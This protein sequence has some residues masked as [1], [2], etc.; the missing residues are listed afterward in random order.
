MLHSSHEYRT[1]KLQL[2]GTIHRVLTPLYQAIVAKAPFLAPTYRW[3]AHRERW[4]P[5]RRRFALPPLHDAIRREL[6][7]LGGGFFLEAGAN[8]GLLFSNTA[9]LERYLGWSGILVEA[10]PHKFV[11]C[12]RNRPGSIVE[13]CALVPPGFKADFVEMR[14]E[15]LMSFAPGLADI[16]AVEQVDRGKRFLLGSER[17]LSDC[18][19]LAP[20]MTLAGILHKHG[21]EKI[22][23][24]VLDVEGAE[25][26]AL[27]GLDFS[28]CRVD[29]ILIEARD[30][31]AVAEF[32]AAY[33]FGD[34]RRLTDLDYLFTRGL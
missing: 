3:I 21:V 17:R 23:F 9:Y 4:P 22:D 8:D 25:L 5:F 30:A 27:R 18:R 1:R 2:F 19:F 20:A 16:D 7:S 12:V 28:S 29:R 14:Y 11:E 31:P 24:M 10:I 15:D 26:E 34:G 6:A 32:L 33:G 13:H